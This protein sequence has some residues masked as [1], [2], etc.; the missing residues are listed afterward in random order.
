M[1]KLE[2]LLHCSALYSGHSVRR[3]DLKIGGLQAISYS[4]TEPFHGLKGR[5]TQVPSFYSSAMEPPI[6]E[7]DKQCFIRLCKHYNETLSGLGPNIII[8]K[9][10]LVH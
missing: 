5:L 4:P 8:L 9:P 6:M 10:F 1:K 3:V 7:S 2:F